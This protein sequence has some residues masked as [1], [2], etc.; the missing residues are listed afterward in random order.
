M[1]T[2]QGSPV[3]AGGQLQRGVNAR[4]RPALLW[5]QHTGVGGSRAVPAMPRS[6]RPLG[7]PLPHSS[8]HT[9]FLV[10]DALP[11]RGDGPKARLQPAHHLPSRL[12]MHSGTNSLRHP[13]SPCRVRA[14]PLT[15]AA[16]CSVT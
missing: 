12:A 8:M 16:T 9:L 6:D 4:R 2:R 7:I 13:G 10:G 11:A 1:G 15:D 5:A 14:L 3:S